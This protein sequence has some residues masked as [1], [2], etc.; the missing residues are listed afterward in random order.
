MINYTATA[1][2]MLIFCR[3]HLGCIDA[4]FGRT[5]IHIFVRSLAV[6]ELRSSGFF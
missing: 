4:L 6:T 3:R 1:L 5:H 2:F